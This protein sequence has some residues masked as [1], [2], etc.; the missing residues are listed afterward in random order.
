M[1]LAWWRNQSRFPKHI[2]LVT[3]KIYRRW[4]RYKKG[5]LKIQCVGRTCNFILL[6]LLV[7]WSRWPRGLRRRSA[8]ARLLRLWVRIPRAAWMSVCCEFCVLS[9]RCLCNKLITRPEESYRLWCLVLCDLESS[10]MRFL[11]PIVGS[12]AQNKQTNKQTWRYILP[13]NLP[14]ELR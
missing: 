8:A 2:V 3:T 14:K 5:R 13:P 7:R 6:K 9:G 1:H 11:W 10:E 4:T 12:R